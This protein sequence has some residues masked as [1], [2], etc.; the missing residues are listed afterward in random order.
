MKKGIFR[1]LP[2]MD[3]EEK[4]MGPVK[5]KIEPDPNRE[6]IFTGHSDNADLLETLRIQS[7]ARSFGH[8][9]ALYL[10]VAVYLVLLIALVFAVVWLFSR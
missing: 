6:P 4:V 9:I 3:R 2:I 5:H 7:S 8:G 10:Q 1:G